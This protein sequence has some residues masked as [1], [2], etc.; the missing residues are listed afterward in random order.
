MPNFRFCLAVLRLSGR[1]DLVRQAAERG[2][3]IPYTGRTSGGH[4]FRQPR[5]MS[6]YRAAA[7]AEV[8]DRQDRARIRGR[9]HLPPNAYDDI[10]SAARYNHN[11]KRFRR[12]QWR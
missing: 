12:T 6:A 10:R 2:L 11:W 1:R 4:Y 5:H 7:A 8:D 3:P 9:L